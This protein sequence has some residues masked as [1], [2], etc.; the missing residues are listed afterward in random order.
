SDWLILDTIAPDGSIIINN[1]DQYTNQETITLTLTYNDETSGID[2]VRYA[3]NTNYYTPWEP[4]Q[5]E[6]TYNLG[7]NT[8]ATYTIYYQIRDKAGNPATF[9]DTIILDTQAPEIIL[10]PIGTGTI[11]NIKGTASDTISGI[12]YLKYKLDSEIWH[13][14]TP[15]DGNLRDLIESF[16]ISLA[17]LSQGTHTISIF[18]KDLAGNISTLTH[19]FT[20]TQQAITIIDPRNNEHIKGIVKVSA[21]C[22]E[23]TEYVVFEAKREGSITFKTIGTDTSQEQGWFV[24]WDTPKDEATC[25]ILASAYNQFNQFLGS[26]TIEVEV[27]NIP[28]QGTL[29][30]AP[31]PASRTI[32]G[33]LIG[34]PDIKSSL[35]EYSTLT[36]AYDNN[37]PFGFTLDILSWNS[38]TYT[39]KAIM[40]DEVGNKG[41][42]QATILIDNAPPY[43]K[44]ISID[45]YEPGTRALTG[46]ATI[47][48]VA[49]DTI[50]SILGIPTLFIDGIETL[51]PQEFS[52]PYG[53]FTWDTTKYADGAHS[54]QIKAKDQLGNLGYSELIVVNV[55][56]G[57]DRLIILTP[58]D[59]SLLNKMVGIEAIAPILT[60]RMLFSVSTDSLTWLPIGT[61]TTSGDGWKA[62]WNTTLFLDGTYTLWARAYDQN[63]VCLGEDTNSPLFIDNTPPD[64]LKEGTI[65]FTPDLRNRI[66]IYYDGVLFKGSISGGIESFKIKIEGGAIE[67]IPSINGQFIKFI[68][69]KEGT[70]TIILYFEDMVGNIGTTTQIIYYRE[71]KITQGVSETGGVVRNPNGSTI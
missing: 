6:R 27:D 33:N 59:Y 3:T 71:P 34:S 44:I 40:E 25:T 68:P 35:F 28:P 61:D 41:T 8:S 58:P 63:A 18:S 20:T 55:K 1:N 19:T 36:I 65:T 16:T 54:L 29:T 49:S 69:L 47:S 66:E 11:V 31:N 43:T 48:F 13:P 2:K 38:G 50:T 42:T 70:N 4:P 22:P 15:D 10:I 57:Q 23:I 32:T 7:T 26:N 56:N 45:A 64:I 62:T 46:T 5:L 52:L 37:P 53:T 39:F 30:I 17:G 24:Y 14:I 9:T 60:S 21:I 51:V 12:S 67:E